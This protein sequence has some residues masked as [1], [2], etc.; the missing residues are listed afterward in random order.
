MP[1]TPFTLALKSS[2][3]FTTVVTGYANQ[4]GEVGVRLATIEP[5]DT[6]IMTTP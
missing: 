3:P 2:H 1:F 6:I 4:T 5:G